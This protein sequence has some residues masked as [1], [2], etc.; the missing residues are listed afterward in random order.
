[1]T[2]AIV[3]AF[4]ALIGSATFG[5]SAE[6][7]PKSAVAIKKTQ[8]EHEAT[9]QR[10][11]G[12][13]R[14]KFIR[15]CLAGRPPGKAAVRRP[16]F[17]PLA[18]TTTP[19]VTPLGEINRPGRSMGGTA[20]S[21]APVAPSAPVVGSTGTS[22]TGSSATSISGSSGTSIGSSGRR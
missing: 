4:A 16:N 15:R 12:K 3:L 21:N 22:T 20:P 2:K 10:Y 14:T 8:C 5:A 19:R 11:T 18:P 6:M 17:D 13:Q 1:M 7:T 9:L